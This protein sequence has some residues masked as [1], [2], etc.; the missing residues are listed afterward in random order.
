L[1]EAYF[2]ERPFGEVRE[3]SFVMRLKGVK[4]N[5]EPDLMLILGDNRQNLTETYMDG[6]ADIVMEVLSESTEA[7]DRGVKYV[8]YAKGGVTEYWLI[9]PEVQT[10]TFYRL[11]EQKRYLVQPLAQG[12]YTTPLLPDFELDTALL[13][14]SPPPNIL[15][16]VALVKQM[17]TDEKP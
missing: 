4:S 8:E 6:A 7:I 5:R 11:N 14:Q 1:F 2:T 17:L 10:A 9:D 3:E 15:A 13:W 16:T 12:I